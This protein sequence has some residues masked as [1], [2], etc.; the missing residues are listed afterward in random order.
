[1]AKSNTILCFF[2]YFG[3]HADSNGLITL[4]LG[5]FAD[6]Q[7]ICSCGFGIV[8]RAARTRAEILDAR[9]VLTNPQ[10]FIDLFQFFDGRRILCD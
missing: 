10:T 2:S 9:F 7:G 4:C 3:L 8:I 5:I 1:M 6:S